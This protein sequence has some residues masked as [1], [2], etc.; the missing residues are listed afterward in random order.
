MITVTSAR[1]QKHL[2]EL[3]EQS[4]HEPIQITRR[5]RVAAYVVS[6]RDMWAWADVH[7][8]REEAVNWYAQYCQ[9]AAQSAASLTDE[10][11]NQLVH[12]L[13]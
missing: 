6:E 2:G 13:R 8:R 5:G 11:V 10:D 3:L 7:K 9:Q 1:A 4:Q 12:E